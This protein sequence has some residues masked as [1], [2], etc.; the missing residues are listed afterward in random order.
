MGGYKR[1]SQ[2]RTGICLLAAALALRAAMTGS[3]LFR[4]AAQTAA[5][6]SSVIQ[7]MLQAELGTAPAAALANAA[8]QAV[9]ETVPPVSDE[10]DS[11]SD[12]AGETADTEDAPASLEAAQT[13]EQTSE[14][15][16][17]TDTD[18]DSITVPVFSEADSADL[19]IDNATGYEVDTA[20]LLTQALPLDFSGDGPKILIVHTHT[21]EAY[22]PSDGWEY[23]ES[24]NLRT[25]DDTCNMLRIG[26]EIASVLEDA[27]IEVL[28]DRTYHDY[29]VYNGAYSRALTTIEAYLEDYPSIQMVLD[30]HRDASENPDG[31]LSDPT[32]TIDGQESAQLLLVVGTDAGG[33]EHPNWQENLSAALKLQVL[34]SQA[35]PGICRD[36]DLRTERFNQHVTAGSL[37][38][39]IGSAGNTMEEALLAARIF[40]EAVAALAGKS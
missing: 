1:H 32:V 15:P 14:A 16:A 18:A 10:T 25:I 35:A 34:L 13:D 37:L 6:S 21:S 38:V 24:D 39:E 17:Q 22:T 8:V 36:L 28:H 20:A 33:L 23:E 7:T 26:D 11:G 2:L 27:G 9:S 30:V 12:A 5:S 4:Q 19:T 3:S 40:A 31:T 29:P